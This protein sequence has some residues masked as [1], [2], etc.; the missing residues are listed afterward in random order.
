MVNLLNIEDAV[1]KES[2]FDEQLY[3]LANTLSK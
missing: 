2:Q 3:E 1:N